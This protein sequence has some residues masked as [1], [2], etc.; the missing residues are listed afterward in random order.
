VLASSFFTSPIA[1]VITIGVIV[2]TGIGFTY[3]CVT[4]M[5]MKWFHPSR[6]GMVSGITVG[7]FGL[8]AVYL[9]PLTGLLIGNFG[10]S[11]TFLILGIGILGVAMPLSIIVDNPPAGYM[12]AS[13][14]T[15]PGKKTRVNCQ[16]MTTPGGRC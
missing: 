5:A 1:M 10:I 9:A 14:A 16:A 15:I 6:K 4:P 12:A 2:A 7:G 3:G 11:R 13:P 8:A